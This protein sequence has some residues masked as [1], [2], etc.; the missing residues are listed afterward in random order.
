LACKLLKHTTG[1]LVCDYIWDISA[2]EWD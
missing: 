1:L 2:V